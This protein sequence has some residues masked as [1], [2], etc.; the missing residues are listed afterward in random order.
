MFRPL[1][2]FIGLRYTRNKRRHQ[3]ISFISLMSMLGIALG[4]VVLITVLSVLN[5]FDREIKKS[6]FSMISPITVTTYSGRVSNWRDLSNKIQ[7]APGIT[8][9]APFTNIQGLLQHADT[10]HAAMVLGIDPEKEQSTSGLG[11]RVIEGNLSD[12]TPNHFNIILGQSLAKELGVTVGDKVTM[13]TPKHA[14]S[15]ASDIAPRFSNFTVSGI[16]RAGGGG[17]DSKLAYVNLS[18]AQ[19]AFALG[20]SV[21]AL[22]VSVDDIYS[23]PRI[24]KDLAD[25]LPETAQVMNWTV[26]LG[27]FFQN[28]SQTKTMMFFIFLL[29]IIVAAFN[30]ICTLVMSVKNKQPDI[31]I[32]RTMGATPR[33]IMTIF[34]IHG[35]AIGFGGILLG[36]I[37][38]VALAANV[39]VV[40][41]WIQNLFNVK[42][43]SSNI[44]YVDFLPSEL[45]WSDVWQISLVAFIL[46]LIA[47]LYPAWSAAKSQPVEGLRYD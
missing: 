16:F 43:L 19:K 40:V 35:A 37:G 6:I 28:I 27:D 26:Q 8:G 38:G 20:S 18:D 5:G 44:Y 32:L 46:S 25:L 23:A 9:I 33:M 29:I 4:M 39:T 36:V 45:Q 21:T 22:H 10:T 15:T 17:F 14:T 31:A 3:F 12:L 42:F 1:A 13:V 34:V 47:T 24:S 41:N 2:L 7:N 30:L 11:D